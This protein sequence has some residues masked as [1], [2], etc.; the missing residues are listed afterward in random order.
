M[1]DEP[2]PVGP[3]PSHLLMAAGAIPGSLLPDTFT[4]RE[5]WFRRYEYLNYLRCCRAANRS[6]TVALAAV[7]AAAAIAA[8]M[9]GSSSAAFAPLNAL[10]FMSRAAARSP[11]A[12]AVRVIA[13]TAT[14]MPLTPL[15]LL[16][17]APSP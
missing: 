16:R 7:P 5:A 17:P 9:F 6:A 10:A 11:V 13:P 4:Q 12:C 2:R 15:A 3:N 14:L 8:A 1:R